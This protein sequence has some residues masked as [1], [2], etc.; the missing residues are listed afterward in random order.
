[1]HDRLIHSQALLRLGQSLERH[2]RLV[3]AE[4]RSDKSSCLAANGTG[5]SGI[6]VSDCGA[7]E[8]VDPC[9]SPF[10]SGLKLH[11]VAGVCNVESLLDGLC[12]DFGEMLVRR[13]QFEAVAGGPGNRSKPG[14]A[15]LGYP[16]DRAGRP[17]RSGGL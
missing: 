2:E 8:F 14:G 4:N 16:T 10:A 17:L 9:P 6:K 13:R 15:P 3:V 7:D 11:L 5:A 12:G 1:M